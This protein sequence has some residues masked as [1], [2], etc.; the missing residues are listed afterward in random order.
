MPEAL[1]NQIAAGE[2]VQRPASVLKE[3]LEN[4]HDAGATLVQVV[5][6]EAGKTLIQVVDDGQG[7]SPRDARMAFERHATSK[8][9]ALPDLFQL[10]TYGFRGEALASI[11]AVAQVQLKTRRP[12]D[13]LGHEVEIAG[14]K[15]VQVGACQAPVGTSISVRN[16]FYNVPARRNFL[17]SPAAELKHLLSEFMHV[18]LAYPELRLQLTHNDALIHDL[19][20]ADLPARFL[21]LHPD[22]TPDD[23]A[24]VAYRT[25]HLEVAG[26]VALPRAARKRR[27]AQYAF[28]NHRYVRSGLIMGAVKHVM[29]GRLAEGHHPAYVL[30]VQVPP[31]RVDVNIHPS[32]TEVKFDHEASVFEAVRSGIRTALGGAMALPTTPKH[33]DDTVASS[34]VVS[35]QVAS[36]HEEEDS[37]RANTKVHASSQTAGSANQALRQAT[38]QGTSQG[39]GQG[40]SQGTQH[41]TAQTGS[42]SAPSTAGRPNSPDAWQ[43][44]Y[45]P[46]TLDENPTAPSPSVPH[47]PHQHTTGTLPLPD[48]GTLWAWVKPYIIVPLPELLRLVHTGHAN[49][50]LAFDRLRA[51]AQQAAVPSQHRLFPVSVAL[52][53]HGALLLEDALP[54]AR[55]LGLDLNITSAHEVVV[56]AAPGQLSDAAL[57][58]L[59]QGLVGE[60]Q[61]GAAA[62][63]SLQGRW[64]RVLARQLATASAY[65][66]TEP[67]RQR[68]Y[69]DLLASP[70]PGRTPDG[71]PTWADL[72]LAELQRR[73]STG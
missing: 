46:A 22:L 11:A 35:S 5:L 10:Q 61:A 2:V 65:P 72:T 58:E 30:H 64:L 8:L 67:E 42:S 66:A 71:T 9:K 41:R 55:K 51:R 12:A 31:E 20:P 1:A 4:S 52:P 43:Q 34:Q 36:W 59:L 25:D 63:E 33:T 37:T 32:K 14:G 39:M 48:G 23:L 6:Q 17:K 15:V 38:G 28:V 13:K 60:L 7:M 24:E 57:V 69:A 47:Q 70:E 45:R 21:A 29:E 26:F 62:E 56:T 16:L 49:Y 54:T 18:A 44:L 3:L 27:D 19:S 68:I 73:F 50:R 40:T 53:D